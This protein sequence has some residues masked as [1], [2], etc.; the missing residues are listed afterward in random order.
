MFNP[1]GKCLFGLGIDHSDLLTGIPHECVCFEITETVAIANLTTASDF[2]KRLRELGGYFSLDDVGC[3]LSSFACLKNLP[4]DY[5][6]IDGVF[7]RYTLSAP[8]DLAM[9]RSTNEKG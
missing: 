2:I 8:M 7:V 5:L 3:G 4:V 9:V 1:I 6:K